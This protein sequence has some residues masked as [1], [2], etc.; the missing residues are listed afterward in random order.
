[1]G[2]SDEERRVHE[3]NVSDLHRAS[4]VSSVVRLSVSVLCLCSDAHQNQQMTN[5]FVRKIQAD[6]ENIVVIHSFIHSFICIRPIV[7]STYNISKIRTQ[8]TFLKR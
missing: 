7:H 5:V 4:R 8:K 1:M 6:K 2:K 3:R